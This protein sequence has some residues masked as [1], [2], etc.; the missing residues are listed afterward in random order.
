[1]AIK[2]VYSMCKARRSCLCVLG[3]RDLETVKG[4]GFFLARGKAR[5]MRG[6]A[7]AFRET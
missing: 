3:N 4:E 1:M 2:N 5:T 6:T 7:H